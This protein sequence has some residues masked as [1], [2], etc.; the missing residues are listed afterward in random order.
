MRRSSRRMV[1]SGDGDPEVFFRTQTLKG[2]EGEGHHREGDV[3]VPALPASPFVVVE[4]EFVF[5]L[6]VALLDPPADLHHAHEAREI[7]A[8]RQRRKPVPAWLGMASEPFEEQPLRLLA[9]LTMAIALG[10]SH[11]PRCKATGHRPLG[12][13]APRHRAPACFG[14]RL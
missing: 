1:G 3:V 6:L 2:E 4:P 7:R 9:L 8:R 13:F 10:W 12:S 5:E 14:Q 11:P